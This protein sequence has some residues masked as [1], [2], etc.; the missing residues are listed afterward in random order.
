MRL[1]RMI[2]VKTK[3]CLSVFRIRKRVHGRPMNSKHFNAYRLHIIYY[4][5]I[6]RVRGVPCTQIHVYYITNT[7]MCTCITLYYNIICKM[8]YLQ[9]HQ[10]DNCSV[11]YIII[12]RGKK[13]FTRSDYLCDNIIR[14][15]WFTFFFVFFFLFWGGGGEN[16]PAVVYT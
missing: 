9:L 1:R 14:R 6:Q 13:L 11:Y 16:I 5:I 3:R 15:A 12:A 10:D 7:I 4:S 2:N 8:L